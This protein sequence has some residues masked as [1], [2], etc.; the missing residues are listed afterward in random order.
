MTACA[1]GGEGL[2]L[3]FIT[4]SRESLPDD[5]ELAAGSVYVAG[6]GARGMEPLAFRG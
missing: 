2:D 3:L 5:V 1:F 4:T 6:V